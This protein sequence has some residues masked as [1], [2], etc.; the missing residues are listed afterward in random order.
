MS[1]RHLH[2]YNSLLSNVLSVDLTADKSNQINQ[3]PQEIGRAEGIDLGLASL[4]ESLNLVE[5]T[6]NNSTLTNTTVVD[7]N[8]INFGLD[9]T[10]PTDK[11]Y[12]LVN[13]ELDKLFKEGAF[14]AV[15]NKAK[16]ALVFPGPV[17]NLS[18]LW[19]IRAQLADR[20]LPLGLIIAPLETAC[21]DL[22]SGVRN[23][24][25]ESLINMAVELAKLVEVELNQV[26]QTCIGESK[27][28]LQ[29]IQN[30]QEL[31]FQ[32]DKL[33]Q[34]EAN[35]IE[36]KDGVPLEQVRSE[37]QT[38]RSLENTLNLFKKKNRLYLSGISLAVVSLAFIY[39]FYEDKISLDFKAFKENLNLREILPAKKMGVI[40]PVLPP[41]LRLQ[42]SGGLNKL[43][44]EIQDQK[45]THKLDNSDLERP[46]LPP[47][48]KE[49]LAVS[50]N[51]ENN[52]PVPKEKQKE[53]ID[54]NNPIETDQIIPELDP[55]KATKEITF[56]SNPD[57][58]QDFGSK[59]LDKSK[60]EELSP[61]DE[62]LFRLAVD[63][64]VYARPSLYSP[65]ITDLI[66]GDEVFVEESFGDWHL[67]R[68]RSGKAGFILRGDIVVTK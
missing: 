16:D 40:A 65:I 29:K 63:S 66:A 48:K 10:N 62:R 31:R 23:E 11:E 41:N 20:R 33:L 58:V 45:A 51:L 68:S 46:S 3:E 57:F 43:W 19:W 18:R 34:P 64:S 25:T 14:L 1:E 22:L 42:L 12:F 17:A 37:S 21:S 35:Y 7:A 44:Y 53:I 49:V 28:Q 32:L 47:R 55:Q 52:L 67:I 26:E 27:L 38:F 6:S 8:S 60:R 5:S 59:P 9:K 36:A 2:G 61:P 50:L 13:Q 4:V 24:H 54:I 39:S 56:P 15:A 30:L